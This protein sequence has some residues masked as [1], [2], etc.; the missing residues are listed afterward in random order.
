MK[1]AL[2]SLAWLL[3]AGAPVPAQEVQRH[4]L[5]FEQWVRATFFDGYKL[6]SHTQRWDIPATASRAHGGAP[7]PQEHP[8]LFGVE[9]PGSIASKPRGR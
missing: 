6:A 5:V 4:G 7:Q 2:F 1:R 8:A 3:A 9:Y